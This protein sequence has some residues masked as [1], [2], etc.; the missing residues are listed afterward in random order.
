MGENKVHW[1]GGGLK[2][3]RFCEIYRSTKLSTELLDW[4][5]SLTL[6]TNSVYFLTL[7]TI[8]YIKWDTVTTRYIFSVGVK[9]PARSPHATCHKHVP[10]TRKHRIRTRITIT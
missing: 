3:R 10:E 4:Y 5:I 7:V 9:F 6:S 8:M 1:G 2:I